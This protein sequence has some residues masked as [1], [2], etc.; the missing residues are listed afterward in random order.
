MRGFVGGCAG[1]RPT[2]EVSLSTLRSLE[3]QAHRKH[4][5]IRRLFIVAGA[6]LL[7][8]AVS[9]EKYRSMAR[10]CVMRPVILAA[11]LPAA[12]AAA[13]PP[14][15][16]PVEAPL[17]IVAT[18]EGIDVDRNGRPLELQDYEIAHMLMAD[19]QLELNISRVLA[20]SRPVTELFARVG[21]K[22]GCGAYDAALRAAIRPRAA[23]WRETMV[24]AARTAVPVDV[25]KAVRS[26]GIRE[27]DAMLAPYR[28][29]LVGAMRQRGDP[30]AQAT[31]DESVARLV[32][33]TRAARAPTATERAANLEELAKL[34][35]RPG[36][37][38]LVP[39]A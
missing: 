5:N 9:L 20:A 30:I 21:G 18:G 12:S 8:L 25:L 10:I 6:V 33:A 22:A 13:P 34:R 15:P 19:A 32:A 36:R 37:F 31:F 3:A 35:S 7:F 24:A 16:K 26:A 23:A 28:M 2:D 39:P 11:I 17:V 1:T 4:V 38:C 29:R 27:G 14:A